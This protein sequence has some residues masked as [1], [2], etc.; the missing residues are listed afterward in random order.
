MLSLLSYQ[1]IIDPSILNA[2]L[3]SIEF[4]DPEKIVS[5]RTIGGLAKKRLEFFFDHFGDREF[6]ANQAGKI[7]TQKN[8][9][10][11]D[12]TGFLHKAVKQYPFEAKAL[13]ELIG[14]ERSL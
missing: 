14:R 8:M 11:G 2:H 4:C 3:S 7:A 6:T 13:C 1:S 10:F 9:G 12:V 5:N